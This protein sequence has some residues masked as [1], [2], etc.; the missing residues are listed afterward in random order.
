MIALPE[1][2]IKSAPADEIERISRKWNTSPWQ[3][4]HCGIKHQLEHHFHTL[5]ESV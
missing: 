1:K 2:V 3:S 4:V 5:T